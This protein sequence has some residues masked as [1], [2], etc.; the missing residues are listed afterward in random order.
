MERLAGVMLSDGHVAVALL[1][2]NARSI[3]RHVRSQHAVHDIFVPDAEQLVPQF[4][5]FFE[6][7]GLSTGESIPIMW[8]GTLTL[9]KLNQ[10]RTVCTLS[11][12][13]RA[14]NC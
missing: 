7:K 4:M 2:S 14:V 1:S 10:G 8:S 6:G 13:D 12:H 11:R 9:L 3:M 5:A